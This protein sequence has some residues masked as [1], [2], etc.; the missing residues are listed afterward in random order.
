M[1]ILQKAPLENSG[2]SAIQTWPG[3]VPPEGYVIVPDTLDTKVFYEF[4]GFVD[5]TIEGDTVT[6][7]T[8]NQAALDAYKA[9]LP[10]P[11]DPPPTTEERVAALEAEN[12]L[13]KEQVSAQADQAEFYE[14]CI[15]EMATVVYA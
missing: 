5:L 9:S 6:A 8:G 7:M 15:A 3:E 14:D 1:Q 11:V 4:L 10:E 12:K 2:H 13:L